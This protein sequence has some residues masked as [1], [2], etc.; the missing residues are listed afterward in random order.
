MRTKHPNSLTVA[1]LVAAMHTP[2]RSQAPAWMLAATTGPIGREA[3]AMA[4]D[5]Q[6]ARTVM[7]GGR[8]AATVYL[9]DTWVPN[10][11]LL[12]GPRRFSTLLA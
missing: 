5:T 12:R 1:V 9:G 7:F 6:R 10:R 4:Y 11:E 2:L 8:T 3:H